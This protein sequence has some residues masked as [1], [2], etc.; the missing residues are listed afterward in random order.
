[1]NRIEDLRVRLVAAADP[2]RA[3]AMQKYTKSAMPFHGVPT[4]L[5]RTIT[6]AL[7][8]E[9]PPTDA[10]IWRAQVAELW[11]AATHREERYAAIDRCHWPWLADR[12]RIRFGFHDREALPMFERLI[13][14][15]AWWDLVDELAGHHVGRVLFRHRAETSAILR[16]WAV[17]DDL[18]KRRSAILAQLDHGPELSVGL[19]VDCIA[20]SLAPSPF[21]KEFF[22]AKAIGWALRQHARSDAAWV[23][24]FVQQHRQQLPA[25]SQREA[26]RRIG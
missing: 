17:G 12:R 9:S 14:A 4:P 3:P 11:D 19:L 21:A 5:R 20:P 10:A 2:G 16:R 7:W 22:I 23:R 15:G 8:T 6:K 1:M 25:L 24:G 13:V 26:M 18:W